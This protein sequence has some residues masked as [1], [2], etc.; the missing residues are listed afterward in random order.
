M[1]NT[2]YGALYFLAFLMTAVLTF[3]L[4]G[5]IQAWVFV[6][7]SAYDGGDYCE[8]PRVRSLLLASGAENG[9]DV[10]ETIMRVATVRAD[11]P[12]EWLNSRP[13]V[14]RIWFS[15]L[16]P[17]DTFAGAYCH[18]GT[19]QNLPALAKTTTGREIPTLTD[20]ELAALARVYHAS[21]RAL[22]PAQLEA[23]HAR[24][25]QSMYEDD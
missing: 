5:F 25:V 19:P 20:A 4:S 3:F 2:Q 9:I 23:I 22:T 14:R 8:A 15:I 24:Q 16:E 10:R 6:N 11:S 12:N 1:T 21:W 13:L 17:D 7:R 18:L